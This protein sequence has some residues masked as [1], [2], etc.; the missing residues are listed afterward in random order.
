MSR[1]RW[2]VVGVLL[3]GCGAPKAAIAPAERAGAELARVLDSTMAKS[4]QV[5]GLI[6]R[7]EA[8]AIGLTWAKAVGFFDR[9]TKTPLEPNHTMR[10]A[11]NTK[12][13]VA[14]AILRLVEDG[15]IGPPSRPTSSRRRWRR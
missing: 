10:L 5:P 9:A 7:V 15:R 14:T 13:Y 3:V 6:L 2:T 4:P 11:S 1:N 8:P 12:T